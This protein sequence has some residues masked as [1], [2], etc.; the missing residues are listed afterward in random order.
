[1]TQSKVPRIILN[2][3]IVGGRR[4]KLRSEMMRIEV[5]QVLMPLTQS[6]HLLCA[7]VLYVTKSER[8]K[9]SNKAIE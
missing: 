1:M 7:Q 2:G 3:H 4:V 5:I 9:Q 8:E 6:N